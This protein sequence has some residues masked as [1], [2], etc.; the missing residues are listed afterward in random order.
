MQS[1]QKWHHRIVLAKLSTVK[2][3]DN[4][5]SPLK[6]WAP[7]GPTNSGNPGGPGSPMSPCRSQRNSRETFCSICFTEIQHVFLMYYSITH[8][9]THWT[10]SCTNNCRYK[11]C[12]AICKAF[13]CL[14]RWA[15]LTILIP[16][17]YLQPLKI[18]WL[19]RYTRTLY[20]WPLVW[21]CCG[22]SY[23]IGKPLVCTQSLMF[24][25]EAL[26]HK[27]L[28]MQRWNYWFAMGI[29]AC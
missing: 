28:W 21:V 18:T 16:S 3:E 9:C 17:Y 10:S 25:T 14:P 1:L 4:T 23:R 8:F 12:I 15:S 22:N 27:A 5:F 2:Y 20:S 13:Y 11:V 24:P 26:Q 7:G 29:C 19:K 6:S